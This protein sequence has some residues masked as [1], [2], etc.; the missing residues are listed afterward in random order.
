MPSPQ[1]EV[2]RRNK[3]TS[4]I[5]YRN[6]VNRLILDTTC[7]DMRLRSIIYQGVFNPSVF[8]KPSLRPPGGPRAAPVIGP[9]GGSESCDWLELLDQISPNL[10]N[11]EMKRLSSLIRP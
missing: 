4:G 8:V 6:V 7:M 9:R 2:T 11:S 5:K 1:E 10:A 3:G